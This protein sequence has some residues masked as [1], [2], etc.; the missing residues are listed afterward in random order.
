MNPTP[1]VHL[2]QVIYCP[3]IDVEGIDLPTEA[4]DYRVEHGS[5]MGHSV[6]LNRVSIEWFDVHDVPLTAGRRFSDAD[7][8]ANASAV[9]VNGHFARDVL[10]DQSAVGRRFR[11]VGLSGDADPDSVELDRWFEIVGVVGNIPPIAEPGTVGARVSHS[12]AAGQFYPMTL[13]MRLRVSEPLEF[14]VRLRDISAAVDPDLQLRDVERPVDFLEG[15]AGIF[16]RIAIGLALLTL[17]IVVLSAAG[18]YALMSCTVEQR[19]KEIGIRAALGADPRR[20]LGAIFSRALAQLAIGAATGV[21]FAALLELASNGDFIGGRGEVVLPVVSI[22]MMTVGLVAAWG[23]A[24]RGLRIQP[25]ETLRT[26]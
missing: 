8:T 18:I 21:G 11:Y 9:I 19:R 12:V 13:S 7:T 2:S 26:E 5:S 1:F 6:R 17:S 20:I 22:L 14:S 24:R 3:W 4:D 16:R 10:G 15:E 23:P 25:I